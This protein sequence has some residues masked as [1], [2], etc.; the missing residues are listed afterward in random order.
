MTTYKVTQKHISGVIAALLLLLGSYSHAQ[1]FPTMPDPALLKKKL[2]FQKPPRKA[3]HLFDGKNTDSWVHR[4]TNSAC[5]WTIQ[6]DGTLLV[7]KGK[8]D[9]L[10]KEKFRDYQLHVEFKIPLL[11]D[12]HSQERGNSGVYNHGLYEV[13][14]LDAYNNP[15]Y[16]FGGCGAIYEQKN[17]DV[18]ACRPPEEWQYYDITFRAPRFDSEGKMTEKPRITVIWNGVK[19]HN[20]V[21]ILHPTRASLEGPM[22]PEG[23]IMLQNHGSPVQYRNIWILPTKSE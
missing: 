6:P 22:T 1:S 9:I 10:T 12:K 18:N 11:P 23:P 3:I 20:D 14:V 15:T 7:T 16:D 13:Q 17:P 5:E 4:G 19:V 2:K 21:E 8:P